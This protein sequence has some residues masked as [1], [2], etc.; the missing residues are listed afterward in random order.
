MPAPVTTNPQTLLASNTSAIYIKTQTTL[1]ACVWNFSTAVTGF[2]AAGDAVRVLGTPSFT[3]RGAG[4][5]AR[6]DQMTPWGGMQAPR[7]GGLGWDIT[8]QTELYW[9]FSPPADTLALPNTQ[10]APLFRAMPW[11]ISLTGSG[12][13]NTTLAVQPFFVAGVD[14][15][16]TPVTYRDTTAYA[17]EPFS[18]CMVETNGEVFAA[19]DCIATCKISWDYGQRIMLDWTIKGKWV[20]VGSYVAASFPVPSYATIADQPPLIGTNCS[21]TM[22][23]GALLTNINA[24]D[25]ISFDPGWGL[26]DVGDM[27]EQYGFGLGFAALTNAPTIEMQVADFSQ[28]V[29]PDWTYAQANTSSTTCV[30]VI[31]VG[32]NTITITLNNVYQMAFPSKVD[33]N[34]HRAT[35]IKLGASPTSATTQATIVFV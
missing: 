14:S 28:T 11:D 1:G 18:I 21:A 33:S 34:G 3:P 6:G 24:L 25:K 35:G 23:S 27:R 20:N 4:I 5:I 19:Y 8:M 31:T 22:G 26:Q 7:T 12:G 32:A 30:V 16:G 10:L 17:C 15:T 29:Q 13:V 2:P 9:Q